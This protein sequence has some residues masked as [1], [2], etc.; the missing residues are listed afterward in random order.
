MF[1]EFADCLVNISSINSFRFIE[2]EEDKVWTIILRGRDIRTDGIFEEFDNEDD[3]MRE[4]VSLRKI[5]SEDFSPPQKMHWP[6]KACC[7]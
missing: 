7:K 2:N 3:A 4:W 5:L 1:I 6:S